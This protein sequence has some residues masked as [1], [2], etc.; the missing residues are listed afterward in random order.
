[1][2]ER[3]AVLSLNDPFASRTGGTARTRALVGG[4]EGNGLEVDVLYPA[5]PTTAGGGGSS[6]VPASLGERRLPAPLRD[7]KRSL[8]PMPTITGGRNPQLELR[9]RELPDLRG[10]VVSALS[11]VAV[12]RSAAVPLWLDFMDLWSEFG[13]HERDRRRG[14]ARFTAGLQAQLLSRTE[15]RAAARARVVTAV[16][17]RD[18]ELLRES[19]VEA[20]W[21]PTTLPDGDFRAIPHR[22]GPSAVG[23]LGNFGFWPNRDAYEALVQHWLPQ[24][25]ARGWRCV[26]AGLQSD[27]LPPAEGVT[28]LGPLADLD[29]FYGEVHATLA[30]IRLGGGMK[31]K[32]VESLARGVPVI[33]TER[34]LEG[35]PPDARA[36]AEECDLSAA[37]PDL[38]GLV[39]VDVEAAALR[40]FRSSAALP[41]VGGLAACLT[42]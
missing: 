26:V 6:G 28:L 20:E 21:L 23:F 41:Q 9:L 42:G 1:M 35:L 8:L 29:D 15:L 34:A 14:L 38:D 13:R 11:Q 40:P 22:G 25:R 16:G 4:L 37:L 24:L 2:T 7:L 31:V 39:P 18:V 12:A 17:W 30:P 27:R 10:V 32:V 36:L 33:G 5:A 3:L 19:G